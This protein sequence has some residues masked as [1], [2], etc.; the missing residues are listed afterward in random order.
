MPT[1]L[2]SS[3]GTGG[4]IATLGRYVAYRGHQTRVLCADPENSV[5]FDYFRSVLAGDPND[6]LTLALS[7]CNQPAHSPSALENT[8]GVHRI[9]SLPTE[10]KPARG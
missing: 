6:G 9:P 5:F 3:G 10:D 1:W 8:Y 7:D 2:V 4:T